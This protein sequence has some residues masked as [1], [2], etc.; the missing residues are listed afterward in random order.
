MDERDRVNDWIR[1]GAAERSAAG[2]TPV[3]HL[4]VDG[5]GRWSLWCSGGKG[6]PQTPVTGN[7]RFCR[8]CVALADEAIEDETL[9][10]GDVALWP[11]KAVAR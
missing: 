2:I 3:R 10:P 8:E 5:N 9:D 11:V 6:R 4:L 1:E 7:K